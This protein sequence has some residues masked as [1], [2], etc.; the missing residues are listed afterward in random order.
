MAPRTK[1]GQRYRI[2]A[3]FPQ[4]AIEVTVT[5]EANTWAAALGRAAR[6]IKKS[7]ELKKRKVKALSLTCVK[8]EGPQVERTSG[9]QQALPV[10]PVAP[11]VPPQTE[12]QAGG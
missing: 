8:I 6:I 12:P 3:S 2:T 10:E 11:A 1:E 5:V 7:P 9:E 4:Q